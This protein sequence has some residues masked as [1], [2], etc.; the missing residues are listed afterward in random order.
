LTYL[1]FCLHHTEVVR[2]FVY[3]PSLLKF[4]FFHLVEPNNHLLVA[5]DNSS[6]VPSD[7]ELVIREDGDIIESERKAYSST[8]H[9]TPAVALNVKTFVSSSSTVPDEEKISPNGKSDD[10]FEKNFLRAVD[11]A[12]GVNNKDQNLLLQPIYDIPMKVDDFDM[13]LVEMTERA[14]SAFNHTNGFAVNK[15][16][17]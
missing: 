5:D 11:R 12:L 15:R 3:I 1:A 9:V 7:N 16:Y 2:N 17:F 6:D 13:N 4:F 8:V 14:L 10:E